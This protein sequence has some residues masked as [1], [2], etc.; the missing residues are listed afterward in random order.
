[1]EPI[2]TLEQQ[3][4]PES[5]RGLFDAMEHKLMPGSASTDR[6]RTL[7]PLD[8]GR[9]GSSG[10][11]RRHQRSRS[12]NA[13]DIFIPAARTG[14]FGLQTLVEEG[15]DGQKKESRSVTV[16]SL[17]DMIKTLKTLPL[18]PP[19]N[20]PR[21][22]HRKQHSLSALGGQR[23]SYHEDRSYRTDRGGNT[24]HIQEEEE[25]GNM[26]E[27]D[28]M[29]EMGEISERSVAHR[30]A[31]AKLLGTF[32]PQEDMRFQ[33]RSEPMS[34]RAS[35]QS[36]PNHEEP[37]RRSFPKPMPLTLDTSSS[38]S[39]RSSRNLDDWRLNSPS[40]AHRPVNLIPFTPTRVNFT[41][42]DCNPHQRRPL[43]IAHLPFSALTPLLRSRHLV[44]GTLRVNK[45][46]RSDAYVYCD[47]LDADIYVC[48]SR[49]RNRALEGDVVAVR[50]VDVDKVLR[51]KKDK[52]EVKLLRNGGQLR[53]RLPDEED[54]NEIIFGGDEEVHIVKPKYCGVV[55]AILERA[56]NQVFSGN[57]T[58]MRPNNKR[59]LKEEAPRKDNQKQVPRIVWFKSS[60]K[61]VPLIAIPIE[62][63]PQA[64]VDTSDEFLTRLFVGS[65]KRWPITSLHPFGT[66]ERELGS[67]YELKTQTK[68]ILAD[69]NVSD[70]EFSEAVLG[71]IAPCSIPLEFQKR[72]DLTEWRMF[73]LD[74]T[75][76]GV[77]ENA[78]SIKRLGEDTYEVG[79]HVSDIS[80]YIKPSSFLDKEARARGVRVD[81]VHHSVPMLPTELTEMTCLVPSE[82]RL[83]FSVIWKMSASGQILDTWFGKTVVKSCA[84]V[85]YQQ[86]QS[87]VDGEKSTLVQDIVN[88]IYSL[89][90]IANNL[91]ASHAEERMTQKRDEFEF[92]ME[93]DGEVPTHISI[94]IRSQATKMVKQWLLLTNKSVAQ[95]IAS[96]F[97]EQAL[98]RRQAAPVDNKIRE[99]QVYAAR[100]L[101][102]TLD[103]QSAGSIERSLQAIQDPQRRK[104][105]SVLV[106]KTMQS[107][108]YFCA[109]V[110]DISKYSHYSLDVPLFT[111]FTA[112]SRCFADILVHRQLEAALS[113]DK[114]FTLDRDTVHKL[115]QHCNVKREA[116]RHGRDQSQLLFLSSYLHK[117]AKIIDTVSVVYREAVVVAAHS[118]H[119]DV[120]ISEL[121]MEKR[122]HLASLPIRHSD[123][124]EH[125]RTLTIYW[126]KGVDTS[127]G[128]LSGWN[129]DEEDEEEGD[130]DEDA[131]LQDMRESDEDVTTPV[132]ATASNISRQASFYSASSLASSA[133]PT[134]VTDPMLPVTN[135][136]A[137]FSIRP[138]DG[139]PSRPMSRR[140]SIVHARLSDSTAYS[141]EQGYQTIK[142]LDKIRVAVSIDRTRAP[143]LIRILAANP[144]A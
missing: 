126:K 117:Q 11:E 100:Y 66:L 111:H 118:Q 119:L 63:A 104:I 44:R 30:E 47:E 19:E 125:H 120:M 17:K 123:F 25:A 110:L 46:N 43:F 71:C 15:E 133:L 112:P 69:N 73:S 96:V 143:P 14:H 115:A 85:T 32:R 81:L 99:L 98:L 132:S 7:P 65:I 57:L 62:Q 64:F 4:A 42:D 36:L 2:E 90:A 105:V 87:V 135:A 28:E 72:R 6:R 124:D 89:S 48:G 29:G 16:D 134:S 138:K 67:V 102:V 45:R 13:S 80:H 22:G 78:F 128:K 75:G 144:F 39:R 40:L 53:M 95:K 52:E 41:R 103:I 12:A 59:T 136:F 23:F 94:K 58:L 54:E 18:I 68:A 97:P 3:T 92:E 1:M 140:A 106:L 91:E 35:L 142:A 38:T 61:R 139:P 107:P 27:T 21:M 88:D 33:R 130:L 51:E 79:V 129:M 137:G 113:N 82:E 122:V 60:D 70:N 34:R 109:G 50:L 121:N 83:A 127:T 49:D 24:Y 8:N 141:T 74:P 76:T 9:P 56:Q 108:V 86:I 55:V 26:G 101:D 77:L 131:M 20:R 31:E 10:S 5:T 84:S 116:A 37:S 93:A 114:R